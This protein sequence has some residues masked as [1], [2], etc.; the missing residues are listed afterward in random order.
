[1]NELMNYGTWETIFLEA[2]RRKG[3]DCLMGVLQSLAMQP[4]YK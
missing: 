2:N 4:T 1:M 3:A